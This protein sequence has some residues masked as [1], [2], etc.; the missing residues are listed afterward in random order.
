M[1]EATSANADEE[2]DDDDEEEEEEEEEEEGEK[3]VEEEKEQG[4]KEEEE[5]GSGG[6]LGRSRPQ[7]LTQNSSPGSMDCADACDKI[8]KSKSPSRW[9]RRQE[10]VQFRVEFVSR[11]GGTA[12]R[13]SVDTDKGGTF[14][15]PERKAEVH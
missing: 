3:E 6:S 7:P 9:L 1:L 11:L 14:S 15:T 13:R 4:A 10:C 8:T 12:H 2:D 5:D